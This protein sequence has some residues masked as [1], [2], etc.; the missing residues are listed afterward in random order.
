[1][2]RMNTLFRGSAVMAGRSWPRPA[3]DR[4]LI[5]RRRQ[6]PRAS[7]SSKARASSSAMAPPRLRTR[8]SSSRRIALS[9]WARPD[10]C[11]CRQGRARV[12]LTGKTVMPAI[13]DTHT[14][15]PTTREAL[16]RP[17][18]AKGVLRCRRV[19]LALARTRAMWRSR[20][21]T[22]SFQTERCCARLAAESRCPSRD[23][24][25]PRTG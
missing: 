20:C 3:Q 10:R 2:H 14:H 25:K 11:R 21:E 7:Q 19:S 9:R 5:Q 13:V 8:S 15:M 22:K 24:P 18:A 4:P 16:V 17:V 6:P 1:M 23:A 12:N